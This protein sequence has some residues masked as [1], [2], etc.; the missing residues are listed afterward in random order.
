ML[1]SQWVAIKTPWHGRLLLCDLANSNQCYEKC[2]ICGAI[3]WQV[4][5]SICVDHFCVVILWQ[6]FCHQLN[7][8]DKYGNG[9]EGFQIQWYVSHNIYQVLNKT[10][11]Q[12]I[13]RSSFCHSAMGRN[14]SQI[15]EI[16]VAMAMIS[17]HF[18]VVEMLMWNVLFKFVGKLIFKHS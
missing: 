12:Q 16:K 5:R 11:M 9:R 7:L 10:W 6:I 17:Q 3:L 1:T 13:T 14:H 4:L 2:Q 15:A 8:Y 18:K